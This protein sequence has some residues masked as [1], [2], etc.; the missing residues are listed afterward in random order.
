MSWTLMVLYGS[1]FLNAAN[2]VTK[3]I[4]IITFSRLPT[5]NELPMLPFACKVARLLQW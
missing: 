3:S 1:A 4:Q 2:M 5:S